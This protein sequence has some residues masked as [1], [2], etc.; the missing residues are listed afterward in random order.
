MTLKKCKG[1]HKLTYG[2]GCNELVDNSNGNRMFG[3]SKTKCKCFQKWLK[4]ENGQIYLNKSFLP[5]YKNNENNFNYEKER[6][7][8]SNQNYRSNVLQK[9]INKI[10]QLIDYNQNCIVKGVKYSKNDAGHYFGVGSNETLS[11]NLHN[12][13]LQSEN[14]NRSKGGEPIE[15]LQGIIKTFGIEYANFILSFKQ[16]KPLHLT[17]EELKEKTKIC[18]KIIKDLEL[19]E[20]TYTTEQRILLRNKYNLML[21][22][23]DLK[24]VYFENIK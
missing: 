12:I 6:K 10:I 20:K 7:K 4:T 1:I 11:L 2:Y 13:F 24:F 23:Y 16:C 15:Y 8:V 21:D 5:K 18:T 9:R 19:Q 14:S 22:I 17:K 3:L